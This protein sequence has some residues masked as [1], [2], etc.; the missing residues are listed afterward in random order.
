MEK[1][2]KMNDINQE[3]EE[4]EKQIYKFLNRINSEEEFPINAIDKLIILTI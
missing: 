3:D 1:S 2:L 4:K